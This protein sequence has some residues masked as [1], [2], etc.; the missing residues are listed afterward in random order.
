M[1]V[2]IGVLLYHFMRRLNGSHIYTICSIVLIMKFRQ[3]LIDVLVNVII[4]ILNYFIQEVKLI[5]SIF[6]SLWFWI[7]KREDT[8]NK[9]YIL[10]W[11]D[12]LSF[13]STYS[14][15]L[16]SLRVSNEYVWSPHDFELVPFGICVSSINQTPRNFH[17]FIIWFF[18]KEYLLWSFLFNDLWWKPVYNICCSE[19]TFSQ[20]L[21]L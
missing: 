2:N 14:I 1:R 5:Y 16:F 11:N 15:S 20:K 10:R 8:F 9:L 7:G 18:S 13:I 19:N 3:P 6:I 12:F 4:V 17:V 21:H